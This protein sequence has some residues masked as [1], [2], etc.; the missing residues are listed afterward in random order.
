MWLIFFYVVTSHR[1]TTTLTR[2][3]CLS[4]F[5]V[6]QFEAFA[7]SRRIVNEKIPIE[8]DRM[9]HWTVAG[10]I[11]SWPQNVQRSVEQ[12]R[13]GWSTKIRNNQNTRSKFQYFGYMRRKTIFFVGFIICVDVQEY[14][15]GTDYFGRT[16]DDLRCD[17]CVISVLDDV[18]TSSK[19]T[20][21][22]SCKRLWTRSNSDPNTSTKRLKDR[23]QR[24]R[25]ILISY[26]FVAGFPKRR[27]SCSVAE[28]IART[29]GQSL[30]ANYN[31]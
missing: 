30:S 15:S 12:S 23:S 14:S 17:I 5:V 27:W 31:E 3:R 16:N 7:S 21:T 25:T 18:L 11:R 8:I 29:S 26:N 2:V 4:L 6:D 13:F 24:E 22:M 20:T 19:C 10:S 28:S 9:L 1:R